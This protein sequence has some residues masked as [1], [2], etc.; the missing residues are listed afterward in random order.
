M[1]VIEVYPRYNNSQF[2]QL[3]P[4][5]EESYQINPQMSNQESQYTQIHM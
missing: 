5:I 3:G 4:V 2:N 1:V